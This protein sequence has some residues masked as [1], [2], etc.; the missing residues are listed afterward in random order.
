[1]IQKMKQLNQ[2]DA[3][4]FY[5]LEN[6]IK[7]NGVE[8]PRV[9]RAIQKICEDKKYDLALKVATN[10][11]FKNMAIVEQLSETVAA[12]NDPE[13]NYYFATKVKKGSVNKNVDVVVT[14]QNPKYSYLLLQSEKVTKN[15]SEQLS[16]TIQESKNLKYIALLSIFRIGKRHKNKKRIKKEKVFE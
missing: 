9:A 12:S 10:F 15:Q 4:F 16:Q 2:N 11:Q 8:S 5:Q 14:S 1:M 7:N 3:F 6:E 13:L